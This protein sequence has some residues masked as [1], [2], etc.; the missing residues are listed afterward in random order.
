[1]YT[2]SGAVGPVAAAPGTTAVTGAAWPG[3]TRA[4][5]VA[6]ELREVGADVADPVAVQAARVVDG[7]GG[8][9]PVADRHDR[10]PAVAQVD[11][12][13]EVLRGGADRVRPRRVV[14]A[15]AHAERVVD[16]LRRPVGAEAGLGAADGDEEARVHA[17]GLRLGHEHGAEAGEGAELGGEVA[18]DPRGLGG[19]VAL[20]LGDDLVLALD[21]GGQGGGRGAGDGGAAGRV[22]RAARRAVLLLVG[23]GGGGGLARGL[24]RSSADSAAWRADEA[25]LEPH[26]VGLLLLQPPLDRLELVA[27]GAAGAVGG[28]P[29]GHQLGGGAVDARAGLGELGRPSMRTRR[30]AP[31]ARGRGG[32]SRGPIRGPCAAGARGGILP[33]PIPIGPGRARA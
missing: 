11:R 21:G 12:A 29:R 7:A 27:L 16:R 5:R 17:H 33:S 4:G 25:A 24:R 19:G 8:G 1:M 18:V 31:G 15:R 13:A 9:P 6:A 23:R 26:Q 10:D 32:R 30:R 20:H 22:R 3:K 28:R 2:G 14:D